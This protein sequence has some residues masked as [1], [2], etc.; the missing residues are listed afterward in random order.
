VTPAHAWAD[1]NE[2]GHF[3]PE[4]D[5]SR[6]LAAIVESSDDAIIGKDLVGVILAWSRGA[7]RLYG[8]TADEIKGRSIALLIPDDR[9]EEL[10]H[11]LE[12]IRSG[13]R[14][15]HLESVRR[16]KS[17]RLVDVSLTVSPI[18]DATGRIVGGVAIARDV[19]TR[20]RD[21]LALRVSELRWHSVIESAV[22]GIIVIDARGHI[23]AFN[24]AAERIFGYSEAEVL[25]QNV[26][27]LMP[28]PYRDQHDGYL[29]RYLETGIAK[30][31][32][33]GRD[34]TGRRRDGSMFPLHLSV[35]EMSIEGEKKFTGILHDL[36]ER[37]ALE[38]RLRSSEARWRSV[39][40]SAVDGIIVIDLAGRIEA[41]NPAAERLFGYCEKDVVGRNVNMLMPSPYH[42]EHD[43]YLARYLSGGT[44]RIIGLGREVRALRRDGTMFPVHLAVG[45][46][47]VNGQRK[48]TGIL[49]DLSAR[50]RMEERVREQAAMAHLGE[51]AAVVA[52]EVRN[53]LAGIRG[54]VEVLGSRMSPESRD[55]AITKEIVARIDGLNTLMKDLLLFARPPQPNPMPVDVAELVSATASLLTVDPDLAAVRVEVRGVAPPVMADPDLLKIVFM[56]LLANGAHAMEGQGLIRVSLTSA[57]GV[58]QIAFQDEGPGIPA[59]IREKIFAPFFTTKPKGTGL[60][61]P[62]V[63]R[64]IDAHAGRIDIECPP[65]GG[66]VVTVHLPAELP[67]VT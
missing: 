63:K 28:A 16:S 41:F 12:Q 19:T 26:T 35:G 38:E 8:Y 33:I 67:G 36:T 42:E 40:E 66:T 2:K 53:P 34:V 21:D 30:I 4:S 20:K 46:M 43:G 39:V 22:D 61:L 29:A 47:T 25:G 31:I 49:H 11:I 56:N 23:E 15:E 60:G 55:A 37:V 64:L 45:E 13:G 57:G 32:G 24:P 52:H 65:E 5:A 44:P 59:D 48:F 9:R 58:C 27:V 50:V 51:M 1:M 7:E 18:S 3:D 14:I 10:P 17:G 62:T 54:A 6:F